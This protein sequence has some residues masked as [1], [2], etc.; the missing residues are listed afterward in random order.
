MRVDYILL[1]I[2][3]AEENVVRVVGV[4]F[5]CNHE[6]L[7]FDFVVESLESMDIA[8]RDTDVNIGHTRS[9]A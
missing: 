7:V 9:L 3:R 5:D 4:H 6:D 1:P 2:A 8:A